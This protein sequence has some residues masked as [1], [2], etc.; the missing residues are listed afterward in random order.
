MRL[1]VSD[2][3]QVG[4]RKLL[5]L[6]AVSKGPLALNERGEILDGGQIE[7]AEMKLLQHWH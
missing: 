7:F 1:E 4:N 6:S 5:H 2:L 3:D